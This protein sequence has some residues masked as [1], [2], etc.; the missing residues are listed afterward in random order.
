M[1]LPQKSPEPCCF[2]VA[3]ME[4]RHCVFLLILGRPRY[5]I[6][7]AGRKQ[8]CDANKDLSPR[9]ESSQCL[10]LTP[11]STELF[12]IVSINYNPSWKAFYVLLLF[13]LLVVSDFL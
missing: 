12:M 7:T 8:V 4:H 13:S 2:Y 11:L 10:F 5:A 1:A 3:I 9:L 6:Q